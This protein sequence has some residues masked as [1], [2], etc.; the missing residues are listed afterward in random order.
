MP[1]LPGAVAVGVVSPLNE[2]KGMDETGA[3]AGAVIVPSG[4]RCC[5]V[6]LTATHKRLKARER[7][8][9]NPGESSRSLCGRCAFVFAD[10]MGPIHYLHSITTTFRE[11]SRQHSK[12][13][14]LSAYPR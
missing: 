13:A 1:I 11:I 14:I 12:Y 8:G 6:F 4:V 10:G 5:A 9:S 2:V 3:G 7:H